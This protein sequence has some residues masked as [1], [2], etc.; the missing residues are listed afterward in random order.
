M[1]YS[2]PKGRS[3]SHADNMV[4]I[5][6]VWGQHL[7]LL[8]RKDVCKVPQFGRE[9]WWGLFGGEH[10]FDLFHGDSMK[11]AATSQDVHFGGSQGY[12]FD[13]KVTE[14]DGSGRKVACAGH[15]WNTVNGFDLLGLFED[16]RV[17]ATI[18]A[19][20]HNC[21]G[22][23]RNSHFMLLV[24]KHLQNVRVMSKLNDKEETF[25]RTWSWTRYW[26]QM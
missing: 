22:S 5:R 8:W 23:K 13:C 1:A 17:S 24:Q 10:V 26:S 20:D 21:M 16:I 9:I 4:I 25:F 11:A 7:R 14:A 18:L 6:A 12:G 15:G 3:P 2:G 19:I